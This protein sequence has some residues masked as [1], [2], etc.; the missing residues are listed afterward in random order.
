M[1][2]D[3]DD[4]TDSGGTYS[5]DSIHYSDEENNALQGRDR[6]VSVE[7]SRSP[8]GDITGGVGVASGSKAKVLP[9][10]EQL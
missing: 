6:A 10:K 7:F 4:L 9:G 3:G 5:E 1:A 8:V 2:S